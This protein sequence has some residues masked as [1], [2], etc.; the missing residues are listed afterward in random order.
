MIKVIVKAEEIINFNFV[1]SSLFSDTYLII[2]FFTPKE[3]KL[4]IDCI[5]LDKFPVIAIP[6]GPIKIAETF[7]TINPEKNLAKTLK[8]LID[9]TFTKKFF[10]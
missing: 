4:S 9:A 3:V 10:V 6:E 7:E 1:L 2:P 8:M 5:I